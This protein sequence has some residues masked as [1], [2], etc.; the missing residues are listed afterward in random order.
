MSFREKMHWASLVAILLGFGFYFGTLHTIPHTGHDYYLS[1]LIAI[2]GFI[3]VA[4]TI[5]AII[6]AIQNSKDAHAKAD[7]RDKMIHMRGTHAAYYVLV[8]GAWGAVVTAHFGH[9]M[10]F[11]LNL[12]L[13]VVV[14]AECIRIGAQLYYY[15]RGH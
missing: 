1:L 8:L 11:M 9:G 2:V 7:E 4:M 3:I 15:R 12:L 13:F 6:F 14:L 10:F 5:S